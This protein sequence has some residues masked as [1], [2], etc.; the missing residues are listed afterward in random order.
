MVI[1][2]DQNAEVFDLY[3]LKQLNIFK[4]DKR[5]LQALKNDPVFRDEVN[6]KLKALKKKDFFDLTKDQQEYN[7]TKQ[8]K[9]KKI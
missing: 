3:K 4:R 5:L 1:F 6:K 7:C 8:K 9:L 2:E